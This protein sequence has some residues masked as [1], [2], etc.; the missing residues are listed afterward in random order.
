[1]G[2]KIVS[3]IFCACIFRELVAAVNTFAEHVRPE[4]SAYLGY[5]S[6][7]ACV[8]VELVS[9]AGFSCGA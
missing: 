9:C 3:K 1:M 6:K 8:H 2:V 4:G 7:V 5:G